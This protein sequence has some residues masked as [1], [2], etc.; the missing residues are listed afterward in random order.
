M[1][2]YYQ[3][4]ELLA[5][6]QSRLNDGARFVET[7]PWCPSDLPA[8]LFRIGDITGVPTP[9]AV[10]G[11]SNGSTSCFYCPGEHV[12]HLLSVIHVDGEGDP[13]QM[14]D[15]GDARSGAASARRSSRG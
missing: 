14:P 7:S 3:M 13:F 15:A 9:L 2:S 10:M 5:A 1:A 12:V 6:E 4:A 8:I 11:R